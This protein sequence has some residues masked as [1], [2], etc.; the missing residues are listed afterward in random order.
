MQVNVDA[1]GPGQAP[2]ARRKS[3]RITAL[4]TEDAKTVN[5]YVGLSL[6]A[7]IAQQKSAA[8]TAV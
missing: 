7:M 3:A 5:V 4:D 2:I 6:P 8:S 1:G